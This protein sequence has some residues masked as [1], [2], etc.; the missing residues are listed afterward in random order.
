[1]SFAIVN[2]R[3]C[4]CLYTHIYTSE[5]FCFSVCR[6]DKINIYCAPGTV[7]S[8]F[9]TLPYFTLH[10]T[11]I[12]EISWLLKGEARLQPRPVLFKVKAHNHYT[13]IPTVQ[14]PVRIIIQIP[15]K[16]CIC[17]LL[18]GITIHMKYRVLYICSYK[19]KCIVFQEE[20]QLYCRQSQHNS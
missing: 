1:M 6:V 20:R 11:F 5:R 15:I 3:V 9:Y 7:K 4:V 17:I 14:F 16:T 19:S 2:V 12:S 18:F 8:A 13:R 10:I